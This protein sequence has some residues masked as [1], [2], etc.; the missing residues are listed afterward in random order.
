M[1]SMTRPTQTTLPE[2]LRRGR[3]W[4]IGLAIAGG[5]SLVLACLLSLNTLA[6]AAADRTEAEASVLVRVGDG[7]QITYTIAAG[8]RVTVPVQVSGA[9]NL[10]VATIRLAYRADSVH[11]V[12]CVRG[13][14]FDTGVCNTDFA[15]GQMKFNVMAVAGVSGTHT[16]YDVVFQGVGGMVGVVTAPLTVTVDYLADVAGNRLTADTLGGAIVV[17]G[18][19]DVIARVG[20]AAHPDFSVAPGTSVPVS[21]TLNITGARA[22]GAATLVLNYDPAVVRPTACTP[23]APV[24]G[25]Y[26]NLNFNPAGQIKLSLLSAAGLSGTV[27]PYV[28]SFAAAPGALPDT[29]GALTLAIE[30]LADPNGVPLA[31]QAISGTIA[32]AAGSTNSTWLLVGGP[33]AAGAYRY[34]GADDHGLDMGLRYA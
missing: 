19:P 28:V 21:I 17:V 8:G 10:A 30:H 7:S 20:D 15:P 3:L 27:L 13:A 16:L 26:C 23:S 2:T 11:P 31:W 25:G 22:L 12:N 29:P 1:L 18:Q 24:D 4:P 6:V 5:L 14:A 9:T 34:A 32:V 33:G